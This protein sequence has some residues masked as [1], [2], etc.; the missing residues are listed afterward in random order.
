VN[1][2]LIKQ[3]PKNKLNIIKT[4]FLKIL[5]FFL[6]NMK[7]KNPKTETDNIKSAIKMLNIKKKG[8]DEIKILNKLILLNFTFG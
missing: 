6:I 8:M 4:V 3:T 2:E 5:N 1:N 7:T